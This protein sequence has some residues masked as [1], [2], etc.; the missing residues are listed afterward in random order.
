MEA[1]QVQV[2]AAE[3]PLVRTADAMKW[4]LL[5]RLAMATV[6]VQLVFWVVVRPVLF[7]QPSMPP[8]YAISSVQEAV[9]EGPDA[10][11]LTKAKFSPTELPWSGCCGPGYRVLRFNVDIPQLPAHGVAIRHSVDS[12]NLQIRINGQLVSAQGR[13]TLPRPTYETNVKRVIHVPS[14]AFH[15]GLNRV[16]YVMVRNVL[17]YFDVHQPV[18]ADYE[19]AWPRFKF[20]EFILTDYELIGAAVGGV[21][22]LMALVLLQRSAQRGLALS[23]LVLVSCWSLL[24]FFYFWLDPPFSAKLRMIYYFALTNLLPVAW[25][26]FSDQWTGKPWRWTVRLSVLAYAAC[27]TASLGALQW[28]PVPDGFDRASD[29]ANWFGLAFSAAAIFRF[30]WHLVRSGEA[31]VW[32]FAVFALCI[33]LLG[34]DLVSEVVWQYTTGFINS[35]MPLLLLAFVIA[36]LARNIQLFQSTHEINQLLTAQLQAREAQLAETYRR[37]SDLVRREAHQAE[38]QR[39]MRDMHDGVGSQLTSMLF[40]ARR[41]VIPSDQLVDSLQAVI[42]EIRLLIDSMDSAGDSLAAALEAFQQRAAK[43]LEAAGIA[44]DFKPVPRDL[45]PVCGPR[46]VLHILR[47]LQEGVGNALRHARCSRICLEVTPSGDAALPVQVV[48]RDDG[49]GFPQDVV[50]GRGL[51][52]METR[53]A[54]I[55][56]RLSIDRS[57]PGVALRL[58]LG[59][60]GSPEPA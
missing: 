39:L 44:L 25:L 21:I 56:G 48:I 57:G 14:S 24:T 46:D 15:P 55:G 34:V 13:M 50:P 11:S 32:E 49:V 38:R 8:L 16:D 19:V 35:S 40:A 6:L 26:N 5:L 22:A 1:E 53:A 43:R 36:F 31:R 58:L 10:T 7:D 41:G 3:P 27:M 2:S 60:G 42:E 59:A 20:R 45:L 29:I 54:A 37:E 51:A 47:I 28:M 33:T 18:F 4:P 12:D 17:P 52:N 23:L 9:L 30:L